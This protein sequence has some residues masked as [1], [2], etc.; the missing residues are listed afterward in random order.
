MSDNTFCFKGR[1]Y[2]ALTKFCGKSQHKF[3]VRPFVAEDG[4]IYATNSFVAVRWTPTTPIE[5]E[6]PFGFEAKAKLKADEDCTLDSCYKFFDDD[7]GESSS[8][9]MFPSAN[10]LRKLF[11]PIL[12]PSLSDFNYDSKYVEP[13]VV[14]AKAVHAG[15]N[16][17]GAMDINIANAQLFISIESNIGIFDV[18]IMPRRK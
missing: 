16:G 3:T 8:F 1:I 10:N 13:A 12:K 4:N 18:V 5:V 15:K 2:N 14:L 7:Y 6:R 17:T 9:I 11:T